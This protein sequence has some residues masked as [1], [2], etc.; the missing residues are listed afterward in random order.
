MKRR[1]SQRRSRRRSKRRSRRRSKRKSKRKSKRRSRRRSA[2]LVVRAPECIDFSEFEL[3]GH[4]VSGEVY[5]MGDN[6]VI[7]TIKRVN[8]TFDREIELST[9]LGEHGI[10]PVIYESGMCTPK[11]KRK[12]KEIGYIIMEK[13]EKPSSFDLCSEEHQ[14]QLYKLFDDMSNLKI[15]INDS[16]INNIMAKD[17]RFYIIDMGKGKRTKTVSAAYESNMM[18]LADMCR[19]ISGYGIQGAFGLGWRCDNID[20]LVGL[21]FENGPPAVKRSLNVL[22]N[23]YNISEE[24]KERL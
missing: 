4:G 7:K 21:L 18:V 9:E 19:V 17:E 10:G 14:K 22:K 13:L 1:R 23:S 2:Q 8:K 11:S 15:N 6:R 16:N 3:L 5:D 12:R 20:T 24:L